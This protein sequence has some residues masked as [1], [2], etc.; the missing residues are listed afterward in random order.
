MCQGGHRGKAAPAPER[1]PPGGAGQ[2]RDHPQ[3]QQGDFPSQSKALQF[4]PL[5]KLINLDTN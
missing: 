1:N 2:Q 4:H 5:S 3:G